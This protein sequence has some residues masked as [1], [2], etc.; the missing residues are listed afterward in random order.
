MTDKSKEYFEEKK[1]ARKG[2]HAK[3]KVK[4]E[5]KDMNRKDKRLLIIMI[6]VIVVLTVCVGLLLTWLMTGSVFK[7]EI[8]SGSE[9]IPI[10]DN[11]EWADIDIKTPDDMNDGRTQKKDVYTFVC[12]GIDID[13]FRADTIMLVTLDMNTKTANVLHILRDTFVHANGRNYKINSFYAR[14]KSDGIRQIIYNTMGIYPN[15]YVTLNFKA[16]RN[17]VDIIG[18]VEID[19]PFDMRYSDPTQGLNINL[20]KGKQLL[21]GDKAEQFVRYR[22]GSGGDGSDESRQKRQEQFLTVFMQK[23]IDTCKDDPAKALDIVTQMIEHM[24]TNLSIAELTTFAHYGMEIGVDNLHFHTLPGNYKWVNKTCYYQGYSDQTRKLLNE[25]L[26]PYEESLSSKYV[27]FDDPGDYGKPD[28]GGSDDSDSEDESSSRG[29]SSGEESESGSSEEDP[30]SFDVID[31]SS[32]S[33]DEK[34][35]SS[36]AGSS[37]SSSSSSASSSSSKGE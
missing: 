4:T 11:G 16:F 25:Y 31:E 36:N 8:R 37:S 30:S 23:C 18:G 12:C 2:A 21:D 24:K 13:E 34:S 27:K 32:S 22:K 19:V 14:K 3:K 33:Q 28:S 5:K 35:S 1:R 26:N 20:K 7:E 6:S 17:I 29:R 15:Y 9:P 10:D